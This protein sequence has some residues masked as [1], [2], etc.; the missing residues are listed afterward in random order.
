M[1]LRSILLALAMMVAACTSRDVVDTPNEAIERAHGAWTSMNE[2]K[3]AREDVFRPAYFERFRPYTAT[4]ANGIWT[5][6]WTI[7]STYKGMVLET[8]VRQA[9]GAVSVNA[10]SAGS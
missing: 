1:N 8:T 10:K 5:V 4:L 6:R 7:P 2:K 3:G 9:D